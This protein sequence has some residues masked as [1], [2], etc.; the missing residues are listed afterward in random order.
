MAGSQV[1][2]SWYI[3]L[4]Q[5]PLLPERVLSD[6]GSAHHMLGSA[7][8][9]RE[10]LQTYHRK[11]VAYGALRGERQ[12]YRPLTHAPPRVLA[13]RT[14]LPTPQGWTT[15]HTPRAQPGPPPSP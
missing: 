7:G 11:I 4:F 14:E 3:G 6:P 5:L 15:G 12:L 13:H 1:L 8:M 10:M 2:K 9:T